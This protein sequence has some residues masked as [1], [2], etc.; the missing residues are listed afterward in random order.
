MKT[1]IDGVN[2]MPGV[3]FSGEAALV[4]DREKRDLLD[5]RAKQLLAKEINES[6]AVEL[7]LTK[8]PAFQAIL[9]DNWRRG[10]LA[11]QSGRLANPIFSFERMVKGSETEYGKI[12]T[13]GLLDLLTLPSRT[14]TAEIQVNRSKI[15]LAADVFAA[16]NEVRLAWLEAVAAEEK[17]RILQ[18]EF[19]AN[20]ASAELA[21]RMK[22]TGNF[23]TAERIREQLFLSGSTIRLA[24]AKQRKLVTLENLA[25]LI[26][27]S[28][29]ESKK[30]K[31]PTRI[32]KL[33][34]KPISIDSFSSQIKTRFDVQLARLDYEVSLKRMGVDEI[35]SY[36]D[37]EFGRRRD[38]SSDNSAVSYKKGFEIE[39]RVPIFDW[40]NLQRDAL[41]AE[42]L[43]KHQKY[44]SALIAAGSDLRRKYIQYRTAFD[45][46]RHYQDQ[47]IPMQESLLEEAT[48]N[49]N[50]MIIG[51]FELL[52]IGREKAAAE[53]RAIDAKVNAINSQISLN[54]SLMG[55]PLDAVEKQ[56]ETSAP[57]R[58]AGH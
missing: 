9:F 41:Q 47:V 50:G 42:L 30:L 27:L 33:P 2:K 54:G 28:L 45:I 14:E 12:I 15:S 53:L 1:S 38:R 24:Q 52:S 17:F 37:I 6:K 43:A 3:V 35:S 44:K 31:L 34:E 25:Q 11:A 13:F 51:V 36:T 58:S 56:I 26:G 55:R 40:G 48:Y 32:P 29:T 23:N 21:K 7:M 4:L 49:Y 5:N 8:S 18:A 16:I 22:Q 57:S 39:L 20:T 46:A 19:T 10:A